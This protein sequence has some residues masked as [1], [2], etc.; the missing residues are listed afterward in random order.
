MIFLV[1]IWIF[2]IDFTTILSFII[3]IG[4][5][6]LLLSLI[7]ALVVVL[8]MRDKKY[9][10]KLQANDLKATEAEEMIQIAKQ[11]FKDKTLRGEQKELEHFKY[12]SMNL[13]YGIAS[14]FYP[15]SKHPFFELTID[16]SLELISYVKER[17]DN[18][19]NHKLLKILRRFKVSQ[20]MALTET[21]MQVVDSK[22]FTVGQNLQK[23]IKIGSYIA[24]VLNPLNLIK[25][26]TVDLTTKVIMKRI[27][28][29]TIGIVGEEAYKI[30]S[31]SYKNYSE[32]I[33][34]GVLD[35]F[36][37]IDQEIL[38]EL[39]ED[40]KEPK[41]TKVI[42]TDNKRMKSRI[43]VAGD[44]NL[45]YHTSFDLKR[46]VKKKNTSPKE[47]SIGKWVGESYEKE[48]GTR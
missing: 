19:L 20:I 26:G 21:T 35:E 16:E 3:G 25:K 43:V 29:A 10:A 27:Y 2:N 42:T 36:K 48:K 44:K 24:S 28:L 18:I 30:F 9:A 7:Y 39:H 37:N 31:K 11:A 1:K 33:D 12:V 8:S 5:G 38:T 23:S 14:R 6:M 41:E 45:D 46:P 22:A 13:V 15:D 40:I 17:L 32:E 34:S 47:V 4:I